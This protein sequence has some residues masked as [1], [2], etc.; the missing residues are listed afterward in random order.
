[1]NPNT[2]IF[3]QLASFIKHQNIDY[4][5][6]TWI[7]IVPSTIGG[8]LGGIFMHKIYEPLVLYMRFKN[9]NLSKI[10]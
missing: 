9:E 3:F 8:I 6:D 10:K 1:M 5:I 4:L 7:L 2:S